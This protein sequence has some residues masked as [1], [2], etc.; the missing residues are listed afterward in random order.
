LNIDLPEV[1]PM[2]QNARFFRQDDRDFVE[3]SFVGA[4]DTIIKKVTP[5]HMARFRPEWDSYCDGT[6]MQPRKGTPLTE[7]SGVD[8][9]RAAHYTARN[10][11]NM[12]E[13]A[14]LNDAQCQALGHG[15]LTL[16]KAA[17]EY[18]ALKKMQQ[19]EK[20]REMVSQASASIGSRPAEKYASETDLA[21]VKTQIADLSQ[22][23]AALVLALAPKKPGRP[24]KD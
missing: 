24:K 3:I 12:E 8:E 9:Q 5:E 20:A 19:D 2:A 14:V 11:H 22:N 15:T 13:L 10:V 21:E 4:K 23:V 6:P 1:Q 7:L 18:L 16:R 17:H